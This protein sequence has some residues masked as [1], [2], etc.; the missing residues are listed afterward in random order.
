MHRIGHFLLL[1]AIVFPTGCS[2]QTGPARDTPTTR[3]EQ[4]TA[5]SKYPVAIDPTKVGT[6]PALTKSGG[7]YFYD[8]VLE[9]RVWITPPAGGADHYQAF[10]TYEEAEEFA[11]KTSGAEKPLVLV[12]QLEHSNEPK[13]GVYE[14]V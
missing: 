8:D 6:Y 13:P 5:T 10:P 12:R 1:M 2:E 7:G 9:Y 4:K 11:R 14:R 3:S